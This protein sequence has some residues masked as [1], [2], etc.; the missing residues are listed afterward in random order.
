[1]TKRA[2]RQILGSEQER[3]VFKG[4]ARIFIGLHG[5]VLTF[6]QTSVRLVGSFLICL[7]TRTGVVSALKT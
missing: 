6:V 7:K 4:I 1:M 2:P 3:P 5:G